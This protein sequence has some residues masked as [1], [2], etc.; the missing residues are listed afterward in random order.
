MSFGLAGLIMMLVVMG[1]GAGIVGGV[2]YLMFRALRA[3]SLHRSPEGDQALLE[4]MHERL[5][6]TEERLDATEQALRRQSERERL[7]PP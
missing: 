2:G 1:L 7:P 5:V 3:R 4:E 6:E